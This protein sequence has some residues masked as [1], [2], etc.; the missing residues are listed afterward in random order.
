M[1][2]GPQPSIDAE[3]TALGLITH[4]AGMND[5]NVL[6][7]MGVRPMTAGCDNTANPAMV[8]GK[9]PEMLGDQDD[10]IALVFVRAE[11]P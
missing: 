1:P 3:F 10:R 5:D 7:M 2:L 9:S 6:T 4:V 11:C 8:K